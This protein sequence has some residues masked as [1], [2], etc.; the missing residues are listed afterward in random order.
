M[1]KIHRKLSVQSVLIA[2]IISIFIGIL[3]MFMGSHTLNHSLKRYL[4]NAG[5]SLFIGLGLFSNG[6]IYNLI[7]PRFISWINRP[8]RSIVI[9]ISAH[10]TYSSVVIFGFSYIYFGKL[11]N[12]PEGQFWNYYKYTLISVLIVTIFITSIIY[13]R[14]FFRAYR[15]EAIEGEKLKQEAIALQ[16]QIMQNQVNPHFLFNSLNILGTLIDVDKEKATD[17]TREL[18]LFYRELLHFKDHELIPL[19][20]EISFVKKYIYLQQIRFGRN[21]NVEILLSDNLRGEVIPMSVQMLL[22]N[23]VKHNIISKDHPLTVK[24]GSCGENEIYV[25]NNYQ[26]KANVDGSNKIGL[27]NLQHRYRFLAGREMKIEQNNSCFRVVVPIIE[28]EP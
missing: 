20:A 17:F 12:T 19:K 25:E 9:A 8:G 2:A 18:S 3:L 24:I 7:E 21:F 10:L 1:S 23:A 16:Y 15:D 26:P 27:K 28:L 14:S 13:A 22:E 6:F 11:L 5:Y 4:L